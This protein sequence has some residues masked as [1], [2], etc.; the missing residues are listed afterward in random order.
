MA[1]YLALL[2]HAASEAGKQ[3]EAIRLADRLPESARNDDLLFAKAIAQ[4]RAEKP[5]DAIASFRRLLERFPN[6]P[7]APGTRI[8]LAIALRDNHQAGQALV[9][10]HQLVTEARKP[11]N[12]VPGEEDVLDKYDSIYP[13][14]DTEL[15]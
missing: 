7:L 11:K 4:Q 12:N 2:A 1:R 6:S 15:Q 8:R 14:A 13:P 5:K 9:Q 3:E 10:L